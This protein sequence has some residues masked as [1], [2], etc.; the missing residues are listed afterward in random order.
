MPFTEG[1][2]NA[3]KDLINGYTDV[4][5]V[6]HEG[7]NDKVNKIVEVRDKIIGLTQE[8]HDG[9]AD[10]AELMNVV[11]IAKSRAKTAADE[12]SVLLA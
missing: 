12:L 8:L 9:F 4:D 1:Q 3:I 11:S 2:L 5:E 7:L 10:N 6:Y